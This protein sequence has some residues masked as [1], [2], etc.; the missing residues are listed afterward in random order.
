M[1][2]RRRAACVVMVV[3]LLVAG[4]AC[5]RKKA[6]D[7]ATATTVASAS[8]DA[9]S[10][11]T[12]PDTTA[13]VRSGLS[14]LELQGALLTV[15]DLPPG[16]AATTLDDDGTD[17]GS[18]DFVCPQATA[19][20]PEALRNSDSDGAQV[21]FSKGQIG[22]LVMQLAGVIDPDQFPVV[23]SAVLG[24]TGQ[25]WEDV[26]DDGDVTTLSLSE[27]RAP[28]VGDDA[29][30]V[31]ISGQVEGGAISLD[32]V[33]VLVQDVLVAFGGISV[34]SIVG[35]APL[36]ANEFNTI[37]ETGVDKIEELLAA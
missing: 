29:F 9:R 20:L 16:W 6:S 26:D 32:M 18:D 21:A 15:Q 37:V 14:P 12:T 27:L 4:A 23:R 34:I 25:T 7:V 5:T 19:S 10:T 36:D 2:S 24:C 35:D 17:D 8:D 13:R 11:G 30:A 31:R 22:P 3:V 28:E 33:F 1:M